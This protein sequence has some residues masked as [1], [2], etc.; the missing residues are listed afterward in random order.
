[1]FV[2]FGLATSKLHQPNLV[3]CSHHDKKLDKYIFS[4]S[5]DNT[6]DRLR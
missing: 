2:S 3:A 4:Q 1:M 5:S 6:I